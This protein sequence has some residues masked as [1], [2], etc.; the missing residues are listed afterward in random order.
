MLY[1]YREQTIG[2]AV[3]SERDFG[4]LR[5]AYGVVI[6][7]RMYNQEALNVMRLRPFGHLVTV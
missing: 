3:I 2:F 1:S 5:A 6:C 7:M 4:N